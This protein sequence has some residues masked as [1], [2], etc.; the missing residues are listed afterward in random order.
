MPQIRKTHISAFQTSPRIHKEKRLKIAFFS[1]WVVSYYY[2]W[3]SKHAQE[4]STF[5]QA[6]I[7]QPLQ[8]TSSTP[9]GLATGNRSQTAFSSVEVG[10]AASS[11]SS[12]SRG[13]WYVVFIDYCQEPVSSSSGRVLQHRS[14]TRVL[15][16]YLISAVRKS[17]AKIHLFLMC[18]RYNLVNHYM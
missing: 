8:L 6:Y 15:L 4:V 12:H 18:S 1:E 10:L 17:C 2:I 13:K 11:K 5:T 14:S 7:T 16:T 9:L 3:L